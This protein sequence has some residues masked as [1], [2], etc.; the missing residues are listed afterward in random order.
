[1][2]EKYMRLG[3]AIPDFN[4]YGFPQFPLNQKETPHCGGFSIA[5]KRI[6][7]GSLNPYVPQTDQDGHDY[8]DGICEIGGYPN[9]EN[10]V[11]TRDAAR[12]GVSRGFWEA[13]A[14][15]GSLEVAEEFVLTQDSFLFATAWYDNMFNPNSQG[16]VDVSGNIAGYHLW[17]IRGRDRV[18]KVW[19]G[20]NSWGDWGL[21]GKFFITDAGMEKLFLNAGEI[22]AAVEKPNPVPPD[23]N[24]D[25]KG[26]GAR[27]EYLRRAL[28]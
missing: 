18:N 17:V 22:V 3:L 25:P 26:C 9:T 14:F 21:K 12:Y 8:Y 28:L 1:M 24:P 15:A 13:Y 2:L 20:Q 23:P 19:I 27:L 10:G 11:F 16:L 6:V 7:P 4:D 5:D